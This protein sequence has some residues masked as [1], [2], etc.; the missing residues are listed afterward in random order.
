MCLVHSRIAG[1]VQGLKSR[2]IVDLAAR[3]KGFQS[4]WGQEIRFSRCVSAQCPLL[5]LF[6]AHVACELFKLCCMIYVL[7]VNSI[8]K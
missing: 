3:P 2:N 1:Q 5:T 8:S 4:L 6:Y 7:I